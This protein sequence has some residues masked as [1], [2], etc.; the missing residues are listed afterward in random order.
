MVPALQALTA[1][2][3]EAAIERGWNHS[4]VAETIPC[5]YHSTPE[6]SELCDI[7]VETLL[8]HDSLLDRPDIKS[9]VCSISTLAYQLLKRKR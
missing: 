2:K 9:A 3:F 8:Q 6:E 4:S 7:V 5:I 1:G